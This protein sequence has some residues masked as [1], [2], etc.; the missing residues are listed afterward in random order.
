M[1]SLNRWYA[2]LAL[3]A[4]LIAAPVRA[5]EPLFLHLSTDEPHRA[6]AALTFGLHQQQAGHPLTVYLSDRGVLLATQAPAAAQAPAQQQLAELLRQGAS[7]LA[8]PLSLK[9]HGVAP[10]LLL[11]GV[12]PSNRALS[13][14]ALFR[15]GT[16]TLSW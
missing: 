15:P 4:A 7:V 11:P 13:S 12:Q 14:E 3:L 6:A 5:A 9:H 2:A 8:V 10:Q 16:R 1:Q